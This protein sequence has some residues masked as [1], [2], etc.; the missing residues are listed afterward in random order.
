MHNIQYKEAILAYAILLKVENG[1][2]SCAKIVGDKCERFVYN[3]FHEKVEMPV[4]K[5]VN[6]LVRL[7]L[8]LERA[9]DGKIGVQA[10]PC[11]E[12]HEVLKQRWRSLLGED[13]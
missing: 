8:V 13:F 10:I 1:Q 9:A 12:A 2:V 7:G 5:A 6:T 11:L 3:V 4:D